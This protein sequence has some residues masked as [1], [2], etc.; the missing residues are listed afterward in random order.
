MELFSLESI[1][2]DLDNP[3][4]N[5]R[6]VVYSVMAIK[7]SNGVDDYQG[8]TIALPLDK[9]EILRNP[10]LN[11]VA[12]IFS[13]NEV[14]ITG[15]PAA[16]CGLVYQSVDCL[17]R[18]NLAGAL[19]DFDFLLDGVLNG[20][21]TFMSEETQ[22]FERK[23]EIHLIFPKGIGLNVACFK[24]TSSPPAPEKEFKTRLPFKMVPVSREYDAAADLEQSKLSA[25]DDLTGSAHFLFFAV[26]RLDTKTYKKNKTSYNQKKAV[27]E[28]AQ[29]FGI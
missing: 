21:N 15:V 12:R 27:N 3:Y 1:T 6:V 23:R 13:E 2:V 20:N 11:V 24:K 14:I 18:I 29:A 7:G 8:F 26:A 17:A 19:T 25:L 9:R 16:D 5:G 4:N 10:D 22:F 28:V